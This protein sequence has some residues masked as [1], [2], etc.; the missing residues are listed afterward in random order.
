MD[1]KTVLK[2]IIFGAI[3]ATAGYLVSVCLEVFFG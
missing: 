3:A 2:Y 1:G